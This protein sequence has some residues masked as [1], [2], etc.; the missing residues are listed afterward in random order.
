[1]LKTFTK[2]LVTLVAL[3]ACTSNAA[4][5]Q[6]EH[7]CG[8]APTEQTSNSLPELVL[9]GT[10][11]VEASTFKSTTDKPLPH[12]ITDIGGATLSLSVHRSK[13]T[14]QL[15]RHF[16]EPGGPLIK[17]TYQAACLSTPFIYAE[18][19]LAKTVEEG[20]LLLEKKPNADGIPA[21]LWIFYSSKK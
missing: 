20:I 14:V 5:H 13:N 1:M 10:D 18:N 2:S 15:E 4:N 7:S 3:C 12:Y 9:V 11:V 19:L 17:Q 21:D 16:Q 6:P 8:N